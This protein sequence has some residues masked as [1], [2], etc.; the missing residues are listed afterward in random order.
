MSADKPGNERERRISEVPG[1]DARTERKEPNWFNRMAQK[2][3]PLVAGAFLAVSPL[4]FG[5]GS[6]NSDDNVEDADVSAEEVEDA[7]HDEGAVPDV[8]E[9]RGEDA[10]VPEDVQVDEEQEEADAGEEDVSETPDVP[11]AEDEGPDVEEAEDS[12]A[13]EDAPP[14]CEPVT[15]LE[16]EGPEPAG[17]ICE[18]FVERTDTIA[19]TVYGEGCPTPGTVRSL[20][21]IEYMI[22]PPLDNSGERDPLGGLICARGDEIGL[23]NPGPFRIIE[24]WPD[25]IQAG[26]VL[27]YALDMEGVSPPLNGG[28]W[29][30]RISGLNGN[31]EVL[32]HLYDAMGTYIDDVLVPGQGR[33][34]FLAIDLLN[35]AFAWDLGRIMRVTASQAIIRLE[36]GQPL[37]LRESF[38][39][40]YTV[41]GDEGTFIFEIEL[42]GSGNMAAYRFTR[43]HY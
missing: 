16:T 12:P 7:L 1:K 6:A 27:A 34:G 37:D 15:T 8:V 9:D 14:V 25:R 41:P 19:V 24:L 28:T 4:P 40:E 32:N 39:Y 26:Y 23:L 18:S 42:D 20:E 21:S 33:G 36:G 17:T 31:R 11:E 22:T 5:C 29:Q 2:I 38:G 10:A 30:L 3:G 35:G 43:D 13:G